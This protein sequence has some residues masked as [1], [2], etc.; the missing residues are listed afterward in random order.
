MRKLRDYA[1]THVIHPL[2]RQIIQR[3]SKELLLK[4]LTS[5]P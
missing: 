2:K 4:A 1:L 5:F 3:E